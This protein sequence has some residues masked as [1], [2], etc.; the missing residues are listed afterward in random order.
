MLTKPGWTGHAERGTALVARAACE[1]QDCLTPRS[2]LAS[3]ICEHDG[4]RFVP[5]RRLN[6]SGCVRT[7]KEREEQFYICLRNLM[8]RFVCLAVHD[9]PTDE[10]Y[11]TM[12]E[13]CRQTSGIRRWLYFLRRTMKQL[14]REELHKR[15]SQGHAY[16]I[17][18]F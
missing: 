9:L 3:C 8:F 10:L 17:E 2:S 18:R 1:S 4:R 7:E 13:E 6:G 16:E 14:V 11:N 15:T 5:R 12:A